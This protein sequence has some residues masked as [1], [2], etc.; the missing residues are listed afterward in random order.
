MTSAS[1][2]REYDAL[3]LP[4]G[5]WWDWEVI[6]YDGS[7]L[8]LGAGHDLSYYHLLEVVFTDVSYLRCPTMFMDAVFRAPT[9][10]E[11]AEVARLLGE[12]PPVLAAFDADA[13]GGPPTP[14]LV[15]AEAVDVVTGHFPRV[16]ASDVDTS[17]SQAVKPG[18]VGAE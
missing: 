18:S 16:G 12:E 1:G 10:E 5:N 13:G 7:R 15:A 3:R 6:D 2:A 9:R 11:S 14:C 8:R 4:E 17:R